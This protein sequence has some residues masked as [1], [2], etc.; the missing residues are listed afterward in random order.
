MQKKK[1]MQAQT[2]EVSIKIGNCLETGHSY[3]KIPL[4]ENNTKQKISVAQRLFYE[5]VYQNNL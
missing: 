3:P 4:I 2:Q 5:N 1:K